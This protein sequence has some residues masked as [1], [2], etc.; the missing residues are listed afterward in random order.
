[1]FDAIAPRYDLLNHLLS[2]GI[3]RR[4]R[5]AAIES[6]KLSGD[7]TLVDVC[8]GTADVALQARTPA[9]ARRRGSSVPP[10]PAARVVGIDFSSAML[11]LGHKK[12]TAAGETHRIALI[13]ADAMRLPYSVLDSP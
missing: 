7:E 5:A 4:W 1:M 3:D 11:V 2:A 13:R 12:V 10:V 9:R 6:L 8:C